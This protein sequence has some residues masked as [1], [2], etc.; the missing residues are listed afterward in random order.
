MACSH[1]LQGSFRRLDDVLSGLVIVMALVLRPV[2]TRK[3][4]TAFGHKGQFF[5]QALVQLQCISKG[6]LAGKSSIDIGG[7]N[8]AHTKLQHFLGKRK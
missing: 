1:I 6:F 3:H 5:P 7:V 4:N 8:G 2:L